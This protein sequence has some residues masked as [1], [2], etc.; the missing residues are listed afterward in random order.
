MKIGI[1]FDNTIAC[2]DGVFY[3]A[4][5][6]KGLI[7]ESLSKDKTSVRDFLRDA[8]KE[9]EW[10]LL[11]GYVYGSRMDLA[12]AYPFIEETFQDL[13]YKG[14]T[15]FIVSHKTKTPY[16][17]PTYDLHEAA[18]RWLENKPFFSSVENAFFELTLEKKLERIHSLNLDIFIDDLPELLS[19]PAFPKGTKR[20]LFDPEKKYEK[21][22]S[23]ESISSWKEIISLI[24]T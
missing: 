12:K 9:E 1:D 14:Y 15:L 2:Y 21:V 20:V 6:E 13:F 24:T 18:T 7:P 5:L 11:Q 4:A 10:I 16:K 23:V 22:K 3:Q 19:H 8:G 17:G